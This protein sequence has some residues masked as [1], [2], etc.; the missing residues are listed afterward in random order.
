VAVD[1][2]GNKQIAGPYRTLQDSSRPSIL[3]HYPPLQPPGTL[4]V[5]SV[6]EL[7]SDGETDYLAELF[8]GA[9]G[10]GIAT[11]TLC[12]KVT[13][14]EGTVYGSTTTIDGGGGCLIIPS[15]E[16]TDNNGRVHIEHAL[17]TLSIPPPSEENEDGVTFTVSI[18]AKDNA[19]NRALQ[20]ASNFIINPS[21]PLN[22]VLTLNENEQA[23]YVFDDAEKPTKGALKVYHI[24]KDI[25]SLS[26]TFPSA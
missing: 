17:N 21:V 25:A 15:A 16:L 6:S 9:D 24:N 22:P 23:E 1:E 2:V 12:V 3:M 20:H 7:S 4:I 13:G 8:D 19:G 5:A 26:F 14:P 10:S 18:N 11:T